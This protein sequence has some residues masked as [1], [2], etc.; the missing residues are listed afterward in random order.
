[1][2]AFENS[3]GYA[4]ITLNTFG[5]VLLQNISIFHTEN[6]TTYCVK[7]LGG[8]LWLNKYINGLKLVH[9]IKL[10]LKYCNISNVNIVPKHSSIGLIFQHDSNHYKV[11][12]NLFKINISNVTSINQSLVYISS[13]LAN[14]CIK[15]ACSTFNN[16]TVA[17]VLSM[18]GSANT[19][20]YF[21][22]NSTSFYTNT[23]NEKLFI[24]SHANPTI[25]GNISFVK[26]MT[27][28]IISL[29]DYLVM[30]N[31]SLSAFLNNLY[32]PSERKTK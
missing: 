9:G 25:Q 15:F 7:Q 1:M 24:V 18:N 20:T 31:N 27:N 30:N 22:A 21:S 6:M 10:T 23:V 26:N 32:N 16:N 14:T 19:S 17:S 5:V 11:T 3:C 29:S 8:T 28:V 2:V 12:V 4:I 13:S